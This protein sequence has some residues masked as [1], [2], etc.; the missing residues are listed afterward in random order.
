MEI[1][2]EGSNAQ[3]VLQMVLLEQGWSKDQVEVTIIQEEKGSWF[4]KSK[5]KLKIVYIKKDDSTRQQVD[6]EWSNS[7]CKDWI[8]FMNHRLYVLPTFDVNSIIIHPTSSSRLMV[9][10][11]PVIIPELWIE[12]RTVF[13]WEKPALEDQLDIIISPDQMIAK[14]QFKQGM[15]FEL[16]PYAKFIKNELHVFFEERFLFDESWTVEE[17]K[18]ILIKNGI[19][20]IVEE[21]KIKQFIENSTDWN[22]NCVVALG[23]P[24]IPGISTSFELI[25]KPEII[26]K[27]SNTESTQT[28][29]YYGF[30]SIH[31]VKVGQPLL[32]LITRTLG[33][34]GIDVFGQE[35]PAT[36]GIEYEVILGESV[37]LLDDKE[38][39]VSCLDGILN[40]SFPNVSVSPM[41]VVNGDVD[42][43]S[44]SIQFKGSVMVNG[45]VRENMKIE[46]TDHVI[47]TG[48]VSEA[49]IIAGL[50]IEL[51]GNVVMSK[52]IA[53]YPH[54]GRLFHLYWARQMIEQLIQ[55]ISERGIH[56]NKT[57]IEHRHLFVKRWSLEIQS[58]D[59]KSFKSPW[60]ERT[61]RW[62]N[63]AQQAC[64]GQISGNT[65]EEWLID[66]GIAIEDLLVS[67]KDMLTNINVYN[68]HLSSLYSSGSVEFKGKGAYLSTIVAGH[69]II[70]TEGD[71]FIRGGNLIA[72]QGIKAKVVGSPAG[73]H[74]NCIV[75]SKYGTLD[76]EQINPGLNT[77]LGTHRK[78]FTDKLMFCR[79]AYQVSSNQIELKPL[80]K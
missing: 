63:V 32:K 69:E 67:E 76:F 50:N 41:Y 28:I 7:E 19:K 37:K 42:L 1:I 45:N 40:V 79:I 16:F 66:E 61:L 36:D 25:S 73:V 56:H 29:N 51:R 27:V 38:T 55:L 5:L 68:S 10:N 80:K 13:R 49:T 21:T 58:D 48:T 78:S 52:V 53:G 35:I 2:R 62:M 65:T 26:P 23:S 54:Y 11:R 4:R 43:K 75:L 71:G 12:D 17:F 34:S 33:V 8:F 74:T 15:G 77:T 59:F 18:R 72:G 14:I 6:P 22:T 44:G 9:G 30:S 20:S 64:L 39:V 31:T 57:V 24:M 47:I 3:E 46:A 60:I 70:N